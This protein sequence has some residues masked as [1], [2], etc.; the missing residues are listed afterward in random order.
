MNKSSQ[1]RCAFPA[2]VPSTSRTVNVRPIKL[3]SSYRP[4]TPNFEGRDPQ[5]IAVPRVNNEETLTW[6]EQS[7]E[8]V[9]GRAQEKLTGLLEAVQ[10]EVAFEMELFEAGVR[11]RTEDRRG[12]DGAAVGHGAEPR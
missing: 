2:E 12:I 6:L 1:N 9:R 7:L 10:A 11:R 3:R 4:G 8:L 5:L